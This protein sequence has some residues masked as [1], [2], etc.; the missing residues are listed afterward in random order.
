[1]SV[2]II[3]EL[4]A[5]QCSLLGNHNVEEDR[6]K[7]TIRLMNLFEHKDKGHSKINGPSLRIM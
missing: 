3:F 5:M 7:G 6:S 4:K 2:L 1:M